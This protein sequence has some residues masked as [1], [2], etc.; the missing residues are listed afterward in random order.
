VD[1]YA[2]LLHE[3]AAT[4]YQEAAPIAVAAAETLAAQTEQLKLRA[5]EEGPP[6]LAALQDNAKRGWLEASAWVS[7]TWGDWSAR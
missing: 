1:T 4:A 3:A 7:A 2:P 6:A 5:M